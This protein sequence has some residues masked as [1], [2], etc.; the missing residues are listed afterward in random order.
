MRKLYEKIKL[1]HE[2]RPLY[3]YS[4]RDDNRNH[5]NS[6]VFITTIDF[7]DI[8]DYDFQSKYK[9]DF[10]NDGRLKKMTYDEFYAEALS[11]ISNGKK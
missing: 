4:Y 9:I 6:I 11:F 2:V 1:V 5:P 3:V 8:S 10:L 7:V